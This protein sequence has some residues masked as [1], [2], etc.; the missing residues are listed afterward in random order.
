VW[1]IKFDGEEYGPYTTKREAMLIDCLGLIRQPLA[2]SM[3]SNRQNKPRRSGG[4]CGNPSRGQELTPG[5]ARGGAPGS[6]DL[7][8]RC[9]KRE[10][11]SVGPGL[12]KLIAVHVS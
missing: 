5:V 1:F 9:T 12:S 11:P 4:F 10:T 7:R 8:V 3:G 6:F 2:R